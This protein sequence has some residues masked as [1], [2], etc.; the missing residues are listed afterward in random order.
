MALIHPSDLCRLVPLLHPLHYVYRKH[1]QI[2][3]FPFQLL[4]HPFCFF[5][6]PVPFTHVKS[7]PKDIFS[8]KGQDDTAEFG[9]KFTS[10]Y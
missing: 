1:L 10:H 8:Q 3:L 9:F 4:L 7:E 2:A 6:F 5:F